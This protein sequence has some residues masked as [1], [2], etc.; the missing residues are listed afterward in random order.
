MFQVDANSVSRPNL[1]FM[2]RIVSTSPTTCSV[3]YEVYR[4]TDSSDEEFETINETYKRI[5][6]VHKDLCVETQKNLNSGALLNAQPHPRAEEGPVYFQKV[7]RDL[8]MEHHKREEDAGEEI[9]PAR[10]RMPKEEA[11]SKEDMDFC[12]KLTRKDGSALTSGG[13]CGGGCGGGPPTIEATA[14]ETMVV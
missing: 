8:I 7:V 11:V 10:Q 9:W 12:S 13:C 6:S 14:P 1:F 2:Q 4:H 3:R 5:M